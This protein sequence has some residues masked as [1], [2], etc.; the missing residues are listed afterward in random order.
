[1]AYA[2]TK[3]KQAFVVICLIRRYVFTLG[4]RYAKFTTKYCV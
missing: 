4:K 1:M 2:K 3:I